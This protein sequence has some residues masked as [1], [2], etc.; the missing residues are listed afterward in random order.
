M[1]DEIIVNDKNLISKV[2]KLRELIVSY[3]VL[4]EKYE[5][6][7]LNK[8]F[9]EIYSLVMIIDKIQYHEFVTFW[10]VLDISYS[11]F[12]KLPHKAQIL[13]NILVSYCQRRRK[14]YDLIGYSNITIQALYDFGASR[15]KVVAGNKKIIDLKKDKFETAFHATNLS[16][17]DNHPIAYCEP[18]RKEKALFLRL[19]KKYNLSYEFGKKH[20]GKLFDIF[21]KIHNEFFLIEARHM[22]EGGD[23][24][25][26][27]VVEIFDFMGYNEAKPNIHYL[28]FME[29]VYFNRYAGDINLETKTGKPKQSILDN[30]KIHKNNFF[31]NNAGFKSML[32]DIFIDNTTSGIDRFLTN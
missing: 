17:L 20:Q 7:A 18:D 5:E 19:C 4:L 13:K 12:C 14:L 25:D 11:Q 32:N 16:D 6:S 15:K 29:G 22:K 3:C 31:V 27:Q 21:L 23:A 8:I 30:L 26:K 10:K 2:N 24:Q 9:K 28:T 1:F